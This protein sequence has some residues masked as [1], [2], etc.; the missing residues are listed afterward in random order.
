MLY[1]QF[2]AASSASCTRSE[3][4]SVRA[5]STKAHLYCSSD[6]LFGW[7]CDE[8]GNDDIVSIRVCPYNVSET[9]LMD[10]ISIVANQADILKGLAGSNIWSGQ[11]VQQFNTLAIAWSIAGDTF[12]IG[13]KYEWVCHFYSLSF[14]LM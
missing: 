10:R 3:V 8:L 2:Y 9:T 14:V 11:N 13:T 5:S 1:V 6:R 4:G 12:S 7:S